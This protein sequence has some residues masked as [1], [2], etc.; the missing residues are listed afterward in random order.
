MLPTRPDR[1]VQ[2]LHGF[3][4]VLIG[5]ESRASRKRHAYLR[6]AIYQIHVVRAE[7]W[8]LRM[9]PVPAQIVAAGAYTR[10]IRKIWPDQTSVAA[11]QRPR[12][13]VQRRNEIL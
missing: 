7:R 13:L 5:I 10:F 11:S 12:I 3:V 1:V 6:G 9:R 8:N 4:R 2:K